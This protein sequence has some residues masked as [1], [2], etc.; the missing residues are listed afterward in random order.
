MFR[1]LK[2]QHI[3]D[4][5]NIAMHYRDDFIVLGKDCYFPNVNRRIELTF[6][7]M[8]SLTQN[9]RRKQSNQIAMPSVLVVKC[10]M[11]RK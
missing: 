1:L 10:V 2:P 8:K 3:T 9:K 4:R 6:W 7:D 5:C 11:K